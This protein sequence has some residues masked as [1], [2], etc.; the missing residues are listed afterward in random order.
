ML[1]IKNV[2]TALLVLTSVK[3]SILVKIS[4]AAIAPELDIKML[5]DFVFVDSRL[6]SGMVNFAKL[7][8]L[9]AISILLRFNALS[10]IQ[11]TTTM[12]LLAFKLIADLPIHLIL[13]PRGVYVPGI[14]LNSKMEL[15]SH[16]L[17]AKST[18][19]IPNSAKH[20]LQDRR[21][22]QMDYF[23]VVTHYINHSLS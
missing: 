17:K 5:T 19:I 13:K 22:L 11:D 1:Q 10:A 4:M 12:V 9:P 3:L 14:L 15:A 20:A 6:L 16:A 7:V 8:F 23:V 2:R 21:I 18:T